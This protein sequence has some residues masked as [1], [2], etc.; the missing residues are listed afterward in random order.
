MGGRRVGHIV[1]G[2]GRG[3]WC[4]REGE[5]MVVWGRGEGGGARE[6]VITTFLIS[7]M[8]LYII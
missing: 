7:W 5:R 1:L 6:G 3:C 8:Y 4:Y 2:R